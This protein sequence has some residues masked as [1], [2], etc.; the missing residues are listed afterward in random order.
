MESKDRN[1]SV[2]FCCLFSKVELETLMKVKLKSKKSSGED[3]IPSYILI[4]FIFVRVRPLVCLV[5][6]PRENLAF[7]HP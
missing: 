4:H 5:N 1:L 3:D 2:Y 7:R 6:I